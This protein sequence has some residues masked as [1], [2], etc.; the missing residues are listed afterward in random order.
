[1]SFVSILRKLKETELE[2]TTS[3]EELL[4]KGKRKKAGLRMETDILL[5]ID[6][7]EKPKKWI[8]L[9]DDF[10][11]AISIVQQCSGKDETRFSL[12]CVHITPK[13]IEACDGYQAARYK[14]KMEIEKP[15]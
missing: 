15:S 13:W 3:K 5:P 2:I 11:E 4:I 7:V 12:T 8:H 1:M 9:P 6:S 10:A 14:M